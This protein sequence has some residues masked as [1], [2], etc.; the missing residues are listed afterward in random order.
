MIEG[1]N[2]SDS[3]FYRMNGTLSG[4]R[5]ERLINI[6]DGIDVPISAVDAKIWEARTCFPEEDFIQDLVHEL[7]DLGKSL[8]GE[9]KQ[10]LDRILV[11]MD[12]ELTQLR[13]S[14]EYGISELK[15]A[16]HEMK[17]LRDILDI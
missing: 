17:M 4:E 7:R 6:T 5:I 8:R 11:S 2:M 1:S 9:K 14:A 13:Q 12:E 15:D 3:E 10:V 16:Q